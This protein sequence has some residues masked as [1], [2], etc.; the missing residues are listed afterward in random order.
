VTN[1]RRP[2]LLLVNPSSGGKPGA[3]TSADERPE[4]TA[5]RADLQRHGL[6]VDLHVLQPKD[7]PAE[8]AGGSAASGHDVVV[9]GGDGTVRP[10]ASSLV[11]TDA[12]LGI[13]PLGSWNN[14]SRGCDVPDEPQAAAQ[15]I[16]DGST[17]QIDV[18]LIWQP[19]GEPRS[20]DRPG[21]AIHFFE[22]AGVGLD[23]A[24]FGAAR[25]GERRGMWF[26]VLS[27]A[28][29]LR[30]RRT[31]MSLVVDGSRY[32]TAAPAVAIC[33]GPYYGLGMSIAPQADPSDGVLDVVFSGMS[34]MDV[35]RHYLAVARGGQRR[36]PRVNT[37]RARALTVAGV[38]RTLPAHADG[39][40]IGVT[41][42]AISVMPGGLRIFG[43]PAP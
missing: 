16:A 33:N 1:K 43:R 5:L 19:D 2:I 28:R 6:A 7:D 38:H 27:A 34:R 18:G 17:R 30:R 20:D 10:V 25:M 22:A 35:I 26:A 40:P 12:T 11:G 23:A 42:V 4:P 9:A 39:E 31:A 3:P 13:I 24:G 29:A 32:R 41:P 14:I 37:R 8:L 15:L 21:N 36:E